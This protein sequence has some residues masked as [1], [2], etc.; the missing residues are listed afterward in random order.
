MQDPGV[1]TANNNVFAAGKWNGSNYND[2][3]FRV[4][5]KGELYATSANITGAITATSGTFTGTVQA[6][7]GYIGG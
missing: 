4:T 6:S 3:A 1:S 2:A 7:G 5:E